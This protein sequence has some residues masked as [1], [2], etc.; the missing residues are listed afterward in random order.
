M[1]IISRKTG[2]LVLCLLLFLQVNSQNNWVR[3]YSIDGL[4]YY[5]YVP[6]SDSEILLKQVSCMDESITSIEI[7]VD[8]KGMS[9][10]TKSP[11]SVD[12]EC[13]SFV[14]ISTPTGS[15]ALWQSGDTADEWKA[16]YSEED[17][18]KKKAK[19][20]PND[21]A[22]VKTKIFES[23]R[24]AKGLI[25]KT[26][27]LPFSKELLDE[28]K[29]LR[30]KQCE[31]TDET[32]VSEINEVI[33][34]YDSKRQLLEEHEKAQLIKAQNDSIAAAQQMVAEK[35]KERN[36]WM[37]VGGIIGIILAVLAF[38]VNQIFQSIRNKRNQMQMMDVQQ[39]IVD[40][41]EGEAQCT[42]RNTMK[43]QRYE[44]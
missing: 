31:I 39:N 14:K 28:I 21:A 40:N 7:I 27:K 23:I 3:G 25:S 42:I 38:I 37:V 34:Q 4:Y 20:V 32:L 13:K 24:N 30:S 8:G 15:I 33:E 19:E 2:I 35:E 43:D 29:F 5:D 41:T 11:L 16:M 26:T 1:K 17:N 10:G 12:I 9:V 36:F 22:G 44:I 18:N 6:I